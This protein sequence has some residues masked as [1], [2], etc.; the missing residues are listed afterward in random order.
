MPNFTGAPDFLR[1]NLMA[2]L[3]VGFCWAHKTGEWCATTKPIK[4]KRFRNGIRPQHSLFRYGFNFIRDLLWAP[5]KKASLFRQC[6]NLLKSPPLV[7]W[8]L[9]A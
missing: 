2:L 9:S 8:E 6:L 3:A 4:F 1:Q 5:R 7:S